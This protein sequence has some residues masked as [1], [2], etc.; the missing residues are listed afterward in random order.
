MGWFKKDS[1]EPTPFID[2]RVSSPPP[3]FRRGLPV[4]EL[5]IR[6]KKLQ[7]RD[8][9]INVDGQERQVPI[10]QLRAEFRAGFLPGDAPVLVT[11]EYGG[12][13]CYC[14]EGTIASVVAAWESA[15]VDS[16]DQQETKRMIREFGFS[17]Y[18][19][20]S[21]AEYNDL[22]RL[23]ERCLNYHR[24]M[25][26]HDEDFKRLTKERIKDLVLLL[27]ESSPGWDHHDGEKK[28]LREVRRRCP[29]LIRT[30]SERKARVKKRTEQDLKRKE[31]EEI[32]GTRNNLTNFPH[33]D[34]EIEVKDFGWIAI[35]EIKP[36]LTEG[37]CSPQTLVRY[38]TESDW[39]ELHEF[40]DDWIRKKATVKQIDYLEALQKQHGIDEPIPLDIS[41]KDI[42]A[43]IQAL[44][45]SRDYE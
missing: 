16:V 1:P 4:H 44:I 39:M 36:K 33:K 12:R 25:S 37:A 6:G 11:S 38:H 14:G 13:V 8:I 41:R 35:R 34:M 5:E 26:W 23:Y 30:E 27:D 24:Y 19:V 20:S 15:P 45:P 28:F 17:E 43:R 18:Q 31:R 2:I 29:D 32:I 7:R 42:S 22:L 40:L 10:E 9:T 3:Q 21:K